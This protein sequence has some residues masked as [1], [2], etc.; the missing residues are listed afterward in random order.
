[1]LLMACETIN[2]VMKQNKELCPLFIS[3]V[4]RTDKEKSGT[5]F[6]EIWY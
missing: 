6:D 2:Y 1:M 4:E 3:S 5:D